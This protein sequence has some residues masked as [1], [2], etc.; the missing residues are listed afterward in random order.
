MR[1]N[2]FVNICVIILCFVLV[3]FLPFKISANSSDFEETTA[4]ETSVLGEKSTGTDV[5]NENLPMMVIVI[6]VFSAG[7]VF[8]FMKTQKD[9]DKK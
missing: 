2:F 3:W 5:V 1:R 7:G 6:M 4:A 9:A 8:T